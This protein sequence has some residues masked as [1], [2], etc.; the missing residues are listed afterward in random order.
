LS[1]GLL[2]QE[3]TPL[4][5]ALGDAR[6][7]VLSPDA[8]CRECCHEQSSTM[9]PQACVCSK[10]HG[11]QEPPAPDTVIKAPKLKPAPSPFSLA[12]LPAFDMLPDAVEDGMGAVMAAWCK[13]ECAR[14]KSQG[15]LRHRPTSQVLCAR[16]LQ[17]FEGK[18]HASPPR[19]PK[20]K[21]AP[22]SF[23]L[24]DLPAFDMLPH[25]MEALVD[26]TDEDFSMLLFGM[27][28]Q[29]TCTSAKLVQMGASLMPHV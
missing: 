27:A 1:V 8:S 26:V 21:L 28:A 12:D 11:R 17:P 6:D 3:M 22:S 15:R 9:P 20:L 7:N 19:A 13:N 2:D 18:Q 10:S 29:R 14:S 23:S 16:C 4:A 24:D 25:A 5:L